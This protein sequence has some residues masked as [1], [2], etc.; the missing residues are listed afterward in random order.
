[1]VATYYEVLGVGPGA[2]GEEVRRAYRERARIHHPDSAGGGDPAGRTM[3]DLN[4]AWRVLGDPDRR[5]DY[6]RRLARAA[7]GET[8]EV[9]RRVGWDDD[10]GQVYGTSRRSGPGDVA[11]SVVRSLPWMGALF[12]LGVIFVFTAFATSSSRR[13]D[14]VAVN[15]LLDR[16]VQVQQGVG[17]VPAPCDG[18]NEG[19]V[20][21][22]GARAS[23]CPRGA[24][25]L[26][27]GGNGPW[28]CLRPAGE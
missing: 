10:Y 19:R 27:V 15:D 16:C 12:V 22:I 14:S 9:G 18:P 8:G 4:E 7:A 24:T 21:A 20:V 28:L 6:D 13:D 25:V 1:M 17:V 26:P 3:Q 11:A 2:T 23:H 5:A